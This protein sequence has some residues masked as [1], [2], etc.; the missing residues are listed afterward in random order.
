MQT[1]N[2]KPETPR[3]KPPLSPE[4]RHDPFDSRSKSPAND[5]GWDDSFHH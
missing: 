1:D 3:K 4:D 2:I 5:N